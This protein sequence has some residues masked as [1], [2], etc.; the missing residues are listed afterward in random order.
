MKTM[1]LKMFTAIGLTGLSLPLLALEPN[2][3]PPKTLP[4]ATEYS[5]TL[6]PDRQGIVSWKSLASVEQAKG[7]DMAPR[8]SKEILDLDKQSVRVQGFILALDLGEQQRHFL[9]SAVPPHCPFCMTVGPE[10]LVEV[11][12]RKA[13]R[14]SMEPVVVSGKLAV[15]KNDPSGMLYRLTEAEPSEVPVK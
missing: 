11:F 7:P 3:M 9:V 14:Y 2:L 8:F 6:L 12:A 4:N 15:L 1:T 13:I 5:A 10:A